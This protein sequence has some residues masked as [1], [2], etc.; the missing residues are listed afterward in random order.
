MVT[1]PVAILGCLVGTLGY[2][3][4]IARGSQWIPWS[5][6]ALAPPSCVS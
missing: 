6:A 4:P 3:I 2:A 5:T 1:L